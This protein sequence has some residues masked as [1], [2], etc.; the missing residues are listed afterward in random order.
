MNRYRSGQPKKGTIR[1]YI[2][3]LVRLNGEVFFLYFIRVR[4]ARYTAAICRISL[5]RGELGHSYRVYSRPFWSWSS[6]LAKEYLIPL[7]ELPRRVHELDS[8]REI[9][10]HCRS[11]K[12]PGEAIDFLGKTGFREIHNLKGGILAWSDKVDPTVP[13][14]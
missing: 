8:S 12:R 4:A 13:K 9:V 6:F 2:A 10:A 14:Y 3:P 7:G 5:Y 1:G 11:G